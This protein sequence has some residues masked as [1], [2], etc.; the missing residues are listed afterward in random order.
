MVKN[1]P[2]SKI[3]DCGCGKGEFT[4]MLAEKVETTYIHGIEFIDTVAQLAEEK[5][6]MVYRAN[7]NE[8]FPIKGGMFDFVH[9]SS[10]RTSLLNRYF[11]KDE[12]EVTISKG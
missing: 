12:G 1:I 7:L 10:C 8:K 9:K 2:N 5:G 6:I 11:H 4:K 3:F